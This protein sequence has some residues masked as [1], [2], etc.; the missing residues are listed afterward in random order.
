MTDSCCC[1]D[2]D[3]DDRVELYRDDWAI[4]HKEHRCT[5]C[6]EPIKKGDKYWLEQGTIHDHIS[7]RREFVTYHTCPPC[8]GIRRDYMK[9]GFFYGH[10]L[11]DFRDCMGSLGDDDDWDWILGEEK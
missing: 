10:V 5:E 7:G 3:P 6:N 1:V 2:V 9:C 4:A 8:Y 11:E